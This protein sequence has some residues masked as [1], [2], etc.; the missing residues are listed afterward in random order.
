MHLFHNEIEARHE[1]PLITFKNIKLIFISPASWKQYVVSL[2]NIIISA[3][4]GGN[5]QIPD[6]A[7]PDEARFDRVMILEAAQISGIP[8]MYL[9]RLFFRE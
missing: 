5:Q 8:A 9:Y 6:F 7:F 4:I 2:K 1:Y 3:E